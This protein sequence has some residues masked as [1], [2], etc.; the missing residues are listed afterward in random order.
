MLAHYWHVGALLKCWRPI[1][2]VGLYWNIGA[3]FKCWRL[4]E[5]LATWNVKIY[6][7]YTSW[8]SPYCLAWQNFTVTNSPLLLLVALLSRRCSVVPSFHVLLLSVSTCQPA[9]MGALLPYRPAL[10]VPYS[11]Y[12]IFTHL[13]SLVL[14]C[15]YFYSYVLILLIV[16]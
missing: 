8:P 7:S 4:F 9:C 11:F 3:L 12:L 10:V 13:Y 2:M 6:I 14:I 15:I 1:E 5:M 16:P